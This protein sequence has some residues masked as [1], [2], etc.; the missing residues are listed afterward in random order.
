MD[1]CWTDFKGLDG[2][3]LYALLR[4]RQEVFVVEQDCPYLD[5]DGQ[6]QDAWH[7]LGYREGALVACLRAFSPGSIYP[8]AVIGRVVTH[9]SAR[10][11]GLGRPL[12]REGMVRVCQQFG[13][14]PVRVS[15]QAHLEPYYHSLGFVVIGPGYDEDGIPHLP[16]RWPG[17][18][19][20]S[21]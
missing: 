8:E 6:D 2:E 16:M 11:Q 18:A 4:L 20:K 15:A 21:G 9:A 19:A 3:A 1:W 12:M 7:L 5:A 17:P 10:G 13:P 14:G